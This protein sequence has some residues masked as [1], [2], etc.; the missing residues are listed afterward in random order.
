VLAGLAD[1]SFDVVIADLFA[2]A[3]TPAHL[4]SVEF[5]AEVRRVLA[6]SGLFAANVGDGP[7]LAHT[8]RRV[9]TVRSLFADVALIA[10]AAVLRGR[11]FGNLVLAAS[12]TNLREAD[13][14]RLLAADPFPARLVHGDDLDT[15]VA[16]APTITDADAELSPVPPPGVFAP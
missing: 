9:A 4:T 10:D 7:P 16:G 11:R 3:R 2:G 13:L 5:T 8:R 15:F 6:P 1:A 12:D 14:I